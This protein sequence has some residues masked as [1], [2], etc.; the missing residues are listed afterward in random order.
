MKKLINLYKPLGKTP[1]EAVRLFK[2]QNPEY[3]NEKIGYAGRLDP[4]A[5]GVLLLLI[6]NENKKIKNYMAFDKE[7]GADILFGFS[8]DTGDVLGIPK[9]SVKSTIDIIGLKKIINALKGR[10]IQKL[11]VFSSYRI[12]GKPLFW[13]ALKKKLGLIKIPSREIEINGAK[14]ISF[15][16]QQAKEIL[17][18]IINKI[19][20]V[21]GEF[22]QNKIKQEWLKILRD[23]KE[24]YLIAK[25]L[26]KCSS[27]T[28]IRVL[29]E[30]LAEQIGT[31]GL[32]F[33][34]I[35]SKAGKFKIKDS[36][37][38]AS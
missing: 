35:R 31:K 22:R 32:L 19:S 29:A 13:Y 30:Q 8:S 4:M 33:G 17:G 21:N 24:K 1:L 6:G 38:V 18:Q 27:G 5:E 34:L 16:T 28:Y 23:D 25:I 3:S 11:P 36:I 14:V 9:K 37:N 2:E 12:A 7:Y 20:L 15:R 10:Q 26:V